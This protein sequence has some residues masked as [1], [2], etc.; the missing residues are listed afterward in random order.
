MNTDPARIEHVLEAIAIE[1]RKHPELQLGQIIHGSISRIAP[2]ATSCNEELVALRTIRDTD[3]AD[4][5]IKY[6][7]LDI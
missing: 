7:S 2:G 6:L 3:F 5:L 1:W 4:A